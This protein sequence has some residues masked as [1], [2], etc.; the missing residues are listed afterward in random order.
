MPK[1][2]EV[3][4]RLTAGVPVPDDTPLPLRLTFWGLFVAVSVTVTVPLK[5]PVA[6]GENFAL[7]VQVAPA[8]KLVPHVPRPPKAKGDPLITRLLIVSVVL[9]WFERVEY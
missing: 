8:A 9:P 3:G 1:A 5:V 2:S 4:E 7:M 6:V